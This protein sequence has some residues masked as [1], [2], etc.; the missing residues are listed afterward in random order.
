MKFRA[1]LAV[2]T[3]VLLPVQALAWGPEG[4][5]IVAELAQ[6]R[7]SPGA[8]AMVERLLGPGHSLASVASW[9][10]DVRDNRP[11]TYNWHFVDLAL[12][13]D[14]YDSAKHCQPSAKGDCIVAAL[15]RLQLALRCA[16]NDDQKREAL[17]FAVHFVGDIHQPMHTMGEGRG[18]N[19]VTV[20]VRLAG[21]KSCRGGPCP[22][23]PY[24]SNLHRVWDSTLIKATTWSWG[25][26]VDRLEGGWLA[27]PAARGTDGGTPAQWAEETH[28][29]AR[30]VWE[31]LP[32]SRV[33]DD[34]Y[35]GKILPTLDRQLRLAGLR[36]ARFLNDVQAPGQCARR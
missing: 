16:P 6:R 3:A 20:E 7:L 15:D 22:V 33:V 4:H 13:E 23:M 1:I 8:A 2:V 28:R 24:R 36:L 12:A 19:D 18:G 31:Q 5:S 21:A 26:Y 29:A 32:E 25:A 27:S 34:A 9:A 14:R 30:F 11:E 17:R 10:D 35:Y